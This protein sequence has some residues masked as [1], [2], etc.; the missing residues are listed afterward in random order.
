MTIVPRLI[1]T[2]LFVLCASAVQAQSPSTQ[3][4]VNASGGSVAYSFSQTSSGFL[5]ADVTSERLPF[6][7]ARAFVAVNF[8]EIRIAATVFEIISLDDPHLGSGAG[9]SVSGTWQD[10]LQLASSTVPPDSPVTLRFTRHLNGNVETNSSN[11][12][13]ASAVSYFRV[14]DGVGS[15][16]FDYNSQTSPTGPIIS[17]PGDVVVFTTRLGRTLPIAD[18][19]ITEA[20]TFGGSLGTSK[21]ASSDYSH[22]VRLY[23]E[24][25]TPGVTLSSVSGHNYTPYAAVSGTI[26]L[27]GNV[28]AAVPLIFTFRPVNGSASFTRNVTSAANGTYSVTDVP[29]QNYTLAIKGNKWLAKVLPVDNTNGDVS[30]V[31]AMLLA[32]DGNNDNF[33]DIADLLLLIAHY[34]QVAPNAGFSDAADFNSDGVNDITD[35]LL[36]VANYNKQ[37][38]S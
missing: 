1:I 16:G 37:G 12:S 31:S 21:E 24:S 15:A 14:N 29:R 6:A 38:D 3:I 27:Q 7:E 34:N 19:T 11:Y 32:G 2:S 10:S 33:A 20:S 17:N 35:L 26:T 23:V 28:N 25:L 4:T 30:E 9:A 5:T 18:T 22:T 36:L 8:G 13:R